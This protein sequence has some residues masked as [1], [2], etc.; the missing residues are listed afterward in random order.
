MIYAFLRV[1][2]G[3]SFSNRN[4]SSFVLLRS[5][6]FQK[7]LRFNA[8][9]KWPVHWSSKLKGV[10]KIDRGT[11]NP[12]L[13]RNCYIDGR[14]G[15]IFG[16]NVWMGPG[17]KVISMNHDLNNYKNYT[18]SKGISIGANCWLGASC[19]ILPEVT[20]GE[21]TIVAAGAVVTKS[22]PEGNIVLAGNPAK[23]IKILS[24]YGE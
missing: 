10:D 19:I 22:F 18:S 2:G 16:E 17:V 15:I 8:H 6:F 9:V 3:K 12:G 20:L 11:R 14:N 4:F 24:N 5:W 7:I 13:A 1:F 21:H 23:P